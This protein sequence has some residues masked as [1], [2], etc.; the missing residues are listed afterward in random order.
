MNYIKTF[1]SFNNPSMINIEDIKDGDTILYQGSK[2][3]VIEN[4]GYVI[5]MISQK[6]G[7]ELLINQEQIKSSDVRLISSNVIKE[8]K[9]KF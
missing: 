1:E 4:D 6:T 5:K 8:G 7:K 3:G 9:N 2:Y